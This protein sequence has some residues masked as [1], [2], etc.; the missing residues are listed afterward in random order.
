MTKPTPKS[1]K[2]D[3]ASNDSLV[4][5]G[6]DSLGVALAALHSYITKAAKVLDETEVERAES[7]ATHLAQ[8]AT[9]VAQIVGELRKVEHHEARSNTE[10]TPRQLLEVCR[11]MNAAD[12]IQFMRDVQAM[13]R[14]GS[15]LS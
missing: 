11:K 15:V 9:R 7:T 4:K 12:R 3:D 13:D 5:R 10:I 14:K 6:S 1:S 2:H 8:L